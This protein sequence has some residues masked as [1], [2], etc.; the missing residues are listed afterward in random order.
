M[1]EPGG[2][3][4]ALSELERKAAA[5]AGGVPDY[6]A[7]LGLRR[8]ASYTE[9]DIRQAYRKAALACHPDKQRP[10]RREQAQRV[11]VVVSRAL[12]VLLDAEQRAEYLHRSA[13]AAGGGVAAAR[14]TR[15]STG[16]RPA[17][18]ARAPGWP[19]QQ[20]GRPE[21]RFG[22][23]DPAQS[24]RPDAGP[25]TWRQPGRS[26]GQPPSRPDVRGQDP[27]FFWRRAAPSATGRPSGQ[28]GPSG[29]SA[30]GRAEP[31]AAPSSAEPDPRFW[32]PPA[33]TRP[34]PEPSHSGAAGP[35]SAPPRRA[36]TWSSCAHGRPDAATADRTPAP[37]RDASG[38]YDV[39]ELMHWLRVFE[40]EMR[41]ER[42][43]DD[44][45]RQLADR[46]AEEA[47]QPYV[48]PAVERPVRWDASYRAAAPP[49]PPSDCSAQSLLNTQSRAV[50]HTAAPPPLPPT[51]AA[52]AAAVA[53]LHSGVVVKVPSAV[54][55]QAAQLHCVWVSGDGQYLQWRRCSSASGA[56]DGAVAMSGVQSVSEA[57]RQVLVTCEGRILRFGVCPQTELSSGRL[58]AALR[59]VH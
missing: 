32:Q 7:L 38:G 15:A 17:K 50:F 6:F 3:G 27:R 30:A 40:E 39:A 18:K 34:D 43:R 9:G 53:A 57:P 37:A 28:S 10:E 45:R 25:R 54:R 14:R 59:S 29:P 22:R 48:P 12:S 11:F 23:P 8:D 56:P 21:P 26:S 31:S 46:L 16:T 5:A 47:R 49:P 36:Y 19:E 2:M 41:A 51:A 42:E 1:A 52:D 44:P 4:D 33:G 24:R 20:C 35:D 55:G 58:A 13:A